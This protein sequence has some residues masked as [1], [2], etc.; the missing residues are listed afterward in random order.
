MVSSGAVK[1]SSAI[2]TLNLPGSWV[3][4]TASA[5]FR[6]FL[7][8]R[9]THRKKNPRSKHTPRYSIAAAVLK[10]LCRP[11]WKELESSSNWETAT[12][13]TL[14]G[15][16]NMDMNTNMYYHRWAH[17]LK[18]EMSIIVYHLLAKDNKLPNICRKHTEVCC[19]PFS[20]CS[21]QTEVAVFR[22]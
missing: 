10:P 6:C 16:L 21:K 13:R 4:S 14:I 18:Q 17:L 5:Q 22:I 19:F 7:I 20:I 11:I 12:R 9:E 15:V 3:T 1:F 8:K 2:L